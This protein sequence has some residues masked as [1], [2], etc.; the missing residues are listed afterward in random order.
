M[1]SKIELCNELQ[2]SLKDVRNG[3]ELQNNKDYLGVYN[4]VGDVQSC[5]IRGN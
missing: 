3:T 5:N 4:A 1:N 2:S